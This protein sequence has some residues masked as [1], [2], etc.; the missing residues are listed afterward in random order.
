M[1][2]RSELYQTPAQAIMHTNTKI[3]NEKV[4]LILGS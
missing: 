3:T 1:T 4:K 2:T